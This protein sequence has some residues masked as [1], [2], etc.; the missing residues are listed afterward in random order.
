MYCAPLAQPFV[1]VNIL[2][3]MP[4]G[5]H[6]LNSN[7]RLHGVF[8]C[9]AHSVHH[10]EM[11]LYLSSTTILSDCALFCPFFHS[12]YCGRFVKVTY[13]IHYI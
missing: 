5:E 4:S 7:K 6:P 13:F 9:R 3:A 10:E 8:P 2:V 12:V 11:P 1:R